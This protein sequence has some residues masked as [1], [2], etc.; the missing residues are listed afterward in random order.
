MN[1]L[2][3]AQAVKLFP[4]LQHL[5]LIREA[6]WKF[7]PVKNPGDPDAELDGARIWPAGWR[8]CIRVRDETDAL[9]LRIRVPADKHTAPSIVWE[10]GGT[11]AEVVHELLT[12]PSPGAPLAPTLVI[13]AVPK[14][15][16]P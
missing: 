5:I 4:S 9:G 16:T 1:P 7:L 12:L 14:L 8:D 6:G 11:L 3:D 10:R 13:G 15:W 2:T